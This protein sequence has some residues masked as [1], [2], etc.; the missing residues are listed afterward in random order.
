M[1]FNVT[2]RESVAA[3]AYRIHKLGI[4]SDWQYRSFCIQISQF[5]NEEPEGLERE[6]SVV[7][8]LV[9]RELW[10]E[11]V[12]FDLLA[13]TLNLPVQEIDNLLQGLMVSNHKFNKQFTLGQSNKGLRLVKWV[14]VEK[15]WA[16]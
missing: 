2:W 10:K 14:I 16:Y 5:R 6:T 13:K 7:W 8:E 11:G 1:V 4:I 3:L 15:V 9:F 12:T